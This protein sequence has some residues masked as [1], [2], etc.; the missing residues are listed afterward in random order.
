M[1]IFSQSRR[2]L[3][4]RRS[5]L[6]TVVNS[7]RG[8]AIILVL[9]IIALLLVL[10]LSMAMSA[11]HSSRNAGHNTNLV[12]A[13]QYAELGLQ[14]VVGMLKTELIDTTNYDTYYPGSSIMVE[15]SGDWDGRTYLVS[16]SNGPSDPTRMQDGLIP[17]ITHKVNGL[18]YIPESVPAGRTRAGG[19]YSL[20]DYYSWNPIYTNREIAGSLV[21][22]MSGRYAYVIIDETGKIDPNSAVDTAYAEGSEVGGNFVKGE[23]LSELNLRD[24]GFSAS[25]ADDVRPSPHGMQPAGAK[26]YSRYHMVRVMGLNGASGQTA[27]DLMN[28][29]LFPYRR[30]DLLNN[31][32]K[33]VEDKNYEITY[34][35]YNIPSGDDDDKAKLISKIIAPDNTSG[36]AHPGIPWFANWNSDGHYA[37]AGDRFANNA[38][39]GYNLAANL[40][41]Y[42]DSNYTATRDRDGLDATSYPQYWGNERVP[43]LSRLLVTVRNTTRYSG[44]NGGRVKPRVS[45][46][47]RPELINMFGNYASEHGDDATLEVR[48]EVTFTAFD[49]TAFTVPLEWSWTAMQIDNPDASDKNKNWSDNFSSSGYQQLLAVDDGS[50]LDHGKEITYTASNWINKGSTS[51][52][53][54]RALKNVKVRIAFVRLSNENDSERWDYAMPYEAR[55]GTTEWSAPHATLAYGSNDEVFWMATAKCPMNNLFPS[56]WIKEGPSTTD[57][58]TG[59]DPPEYWNDPKSR[60]NIRNGPMEHLV[61]LG[62][63]WRMEPPSDSDDS[64]VFRTLNLIDYSYASDNTVPDDYSDSMDGSVDN[65]DDA[66]YDTEGNG[67]DR[68]IVD[69][70]RIGNTDADARVMIGRI[71]INSRQTA[72][73][74]ALFKRVTS[75]RYTSGDPITSAQISQ[76]VTHIKNKTLPDSTDPKSS[77]PLPLGK[78]DNNRNAPLY[79]LLFQPGDLPGLSE[80]QLEHLLMQTVMLVNGKHNYFTCVV[81]A[82]TLQDVGG[83]DTE[84]MINGVPAMFGR[85]D[86]GADQILAEQKIR[87]ILYRNAV[88][89]VV[90]VERFDY[91]DE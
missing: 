19:T 6:S 44:S 67:G 83:V 31:Q 24:L 74:E 73:L 26:W 62:A 36:S 40:K 55:F 86:L 46:F 39:Y 64:Q 28:S 68:S 16:L 69:M 79:G 37:S 90:T 35:L 47:L 60:I 65:W 9:G 2:R 30:P 51:T 84:V 50:R 61:E 20:N 63:I 52:S 32:R 45:V 53:T 82:Q 23:Y 1:R 58:M 66:S 18:S 81:A 22:V 15:G 87:V 33:L 49:N 38:T 80:D 85:Y 70:V 7:R 42:W 41:D 4:G 71:N 29:T 77:G 27:L 34:N 48:G 11:I 75:A 88:T 17:A 89:N 54:A 12:Q 91:L 59:V 78:F 3:R 57:P 56:D 25:F 21:Q 5:R 43:Y 10:A 72:V 13:R 8:V 14:R 76:L